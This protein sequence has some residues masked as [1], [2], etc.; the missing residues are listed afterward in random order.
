MARRLFNKGAVLSQV[1]S[2]SLL[3]VGHAVGEALA[4]ERVAPP[5]QAA[6]VAP[7]FELNCKKDWM[8]CHGF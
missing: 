5:R 8:E 6:G 2:D 4:G 7:S 3:G 1:L